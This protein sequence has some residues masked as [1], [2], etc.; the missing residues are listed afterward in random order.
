MTFK[1]E[2]LNEA[3]KHADLTRS[4]LL[5]TWGRLALKLGMARRLIKIRV[6]FLLCVCCF[7]LASCASQQ[8]VDTNTTLYYNKQAVQ[9]FKHK[10]R[11]TLY[12]ATS[13]DDMQ[14]DSYAGVVM[15]KIQK[16]WVDG[17]KVTGHKNI[18]R[19][20]RPSLADYG[21]VMGYGVGGSQENVGSE[22]E[23]VGNGKFVSDSYSYTTYNKW[24]N[25]DII[26]LKHSTLDH[27]KYIY[28]G[29]AIVS[30]GYRSVNSV[31]KCMIW[32]LLDNLDQQKSGTTQTWWDPKDD[33]CVT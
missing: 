6:N 19:V 31:H 24:F 21:V 22:P 4:F 13:K 1:K 14:Y 10:K 33:G 29:K 16:W 30:D 17:G 9:S 27:P 18:V 15:A 8:G 5:S 12:F 32:S 20:Y 2:T 11:I 26:D 23:Y 25:I 28:Q 7:A 3:L